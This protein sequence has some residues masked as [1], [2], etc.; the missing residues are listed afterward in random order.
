[1]G[2]QA[3]PIG[4][5][6][7]QR[8]YLMM[9][10]MGEIV[11]KIIGLQGG[12]SVDRVVGGPEQSLQVFSCPGDDGDH[13][14]AQDTGKHLAVQPVAPGSGL[15]HKVE[16][17][18]QRAFQFQKLDGQVK[19]AFDIGGVHDVD[20]DVG[21]FV[22][23][24]FTGNNFLHGVRR[25][26][27][28]SGQIHNGD[29]IAVHLGLA[30]FLLHRDTGP[31]AYVLV[32]AGEGVEQRG[33]SAVGIARKGQFK[34]PAV[35]TRQVA[36]VVGFFLEFVRLHP[37][38][39]FVVR[40]M[41]HH[42]CAFMGMGPLDRRLA[43]GTEHDLPGVL[44]AYGKLIVPEIDLNGVPHGGYLADQ[45]RCAGSDAHIDEPPPHRA[46]FPAEA[47]NDTAFSGGKLL[48]GLLR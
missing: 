14:N 36:A 2:G 1:M 15:V 42:T 31:V 6:V 21:V 27:V 16:G 4:F 3:H 17:N 29:R 44:P 37:K 23:D 19:V 45:N 39:G 47:L 25:Q 10:F 13:G 11:V 32:G 28:Y 40:N 38:E 43:G 9:N 20:D 35:L 24:K 12:S 46:F 22:N 33:F 7:D 5:I 26:G 18:N 34:D 48:E 30:L 41:L 8:A